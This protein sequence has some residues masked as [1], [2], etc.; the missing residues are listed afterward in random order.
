MYNNYCDEAVSKQLPFRPGDKA[1]KGTAA[2]KR[3]WFTSGFTIAHGQARKYCVP[4]CFSLYDKAEVVS[5]LA[6]GVLSE[7]ECMN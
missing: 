2:A 3:L 5:R 6:G 7:T 4:S 1:L